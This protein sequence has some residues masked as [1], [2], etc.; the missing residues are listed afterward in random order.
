MLE[1]PQAVLVEAHVESLGLD[2]NTKNPVLILKEDD[3]TR[4]LPIWIGPGE[5]SAIAVELAKM[6]FPRPLTHDLLIAVV[7][8]L[9][10]ALRRV[11]IT[12]VVQDTFYAELVIQRNGSTVEVDARPSDSIA[13]ALRA[14]AEIFV[15]DS[16]LE[17]VELEVVDDKGTEEPIEE[18]HDPSQ[19]SER[20]P[21]K[22][23]ALEEYLRKLNPEDFGRFNP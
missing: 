5:A 15:E 14:G 17:D 13:L 10:G 19:P 11:N 21:L 9:G 8:D 4:I 2:R 6:Q 18:S 3:G 20:P 7:G 12:R 1:R 22:A 16:L 23:E